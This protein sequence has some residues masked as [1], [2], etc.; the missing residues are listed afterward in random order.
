MKNQWLKLIWN[1]TY[2]SIALRDGLITVCFRVEHTIVS[3][4]PR[5]TWWRSR[6][7]DRSTDT[8]CAYVRPPCWNWTQTIHVRVRLPKP[9]VAMTSSR[10]LLVLHD[11]EEGH[12]IYDLL[13]LGSEEDPETQTLSCFPHPVACFPAGLGCRAFAVSGGSILGSGGRR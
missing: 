3:S 12:L 5:G 7:I 1:I 13:L 9:K 10:P 8:A 6:S 11:E 4:C 2:L